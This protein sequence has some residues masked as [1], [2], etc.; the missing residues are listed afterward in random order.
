[1]NMPRLTSIIGRNI[2]L[3]GAWI[4]SAA[5]LSYFC[6]YMYRKPYT[7]AVF[8]G[9][10]LW[11]VDY[12]ILLIISQV[13][14]YAVSKFIGV[15]VISELKSKGR[16]KL[17]LGAILVSWL[18]L[19][20]FAFLPRSMGPF[21]LFIN[22]LPLG[23]IWGIVFSYCEGRKLTEVITVFLASNFILT[24]GIAKSIGRYLIGLGV[25]EYQ[26][27]MLVGLLILPLLVLSLWMLEKVPPPS[28][29]EVKHKT[30]RLP[31]DKASRWSFLRSYAV[32]ISCF[33][34][35]YLILTIIRDVRDN[36]AVEIW[37]T[38]GYG[39]NPS[40]YTSMELPVTVFVLFSLGLLYRI[41]DNMK[42]LIYNVLIS[43]LGLALLLGSTWMFQAGLLSSVSWMII[44]GAGLFLP[45]ILL[46]GIIFDRFI[47]AFHIVGNVGFIMYIADA[48]G[49]LGSIF[50]MLNK[51]FMNV[52]LNWLDFYIRLCYI[53]GL[54]GLVVVSILLFHFYKSSSLKKA[55]PA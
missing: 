38:L 53:G 44:S 2:W 17:F 36:F 55:T 49:Y 23:L 10:V 13:L 25:T 22:G 16:V 26:M 14:G 33:V 50:I 51:N 37:T 18:G 54:V 6:M 27:P 46:N 8:D 3:Q 20:G 4:S 35:L 39:G 34:V 43:L 5:F 31:M 41:K 12:K 30:E 19:L 29:E 47:A 7:A 9:E 52:D 1:M 15:K 11:G 32:A 28:E 45:Y 42:A 40:I 21:M 24:S 48:T